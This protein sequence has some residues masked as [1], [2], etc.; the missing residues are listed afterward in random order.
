MAKSQQ[1]ERF[2][3]QVGFYAFNRWARRQGLSLEATRAV[4]R[5]VF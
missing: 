5:N 2:A 1:L 3:H 4:I